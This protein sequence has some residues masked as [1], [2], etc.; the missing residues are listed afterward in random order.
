MSQNTCKEGA[1]ARL[2]KSKTASQ[3]AAG[4][5]MGVMI[6]KNGLARARQAIYHP[7]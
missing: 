2:Q 6:S 3:I 1:A 5:E 7:D 4:G